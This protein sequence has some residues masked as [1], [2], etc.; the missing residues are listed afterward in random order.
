[1]LS[2]WEALVFKINKCFV[3]FQAKY[4]KHE[5][6]VVKSKEMFFAKINYFQKM[7]KFGRK[8]RTN[9]V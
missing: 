8:M 7:M 2:N 3:E 9:F 6:M 5:K 1:M 4:Q